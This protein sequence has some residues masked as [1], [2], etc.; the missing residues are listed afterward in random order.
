MVGEQATK[1]PWYRMRRYIHFDD[2]VSISAAEALVTNP[3]RVAKHAF[4]PL[5]GFRH[6]ERRWKRMDKKWKFKSRPIAYAS[7][8]DSHIF[9]YYSWVLGQLYEVALNTAGLSDV[10]LAYRKH[11]VNPTESDKGKTNYHFAAEAFEEIATRPSCEVVALDVERFFDTIPHKQM[12]AKWRWLLKGDD[13]PSDHYNIYKA[14]T[15][16]SVVTLTQIRKSL[17]IGRRKYSKLRSIGISSAEFDRL[18]R[19]RGLINVN[20][21]QY[22]IPQGLPISGLLANLVMFNVDVE[23]HN[24]AESAGASY[25]RY[26]DDILIIAPPGGAPG[27][28]AKLKLC[29][30]SLGL[31]VQDSKTARIQCE[32]DASGKL[33]ASKPISYLG[34]EFDG[35][36]VILRQQT[37]VR[38]QKRM[39]RSVRRARNAAKKSARPG[40]PIRIRRRDLYT[41][42]SHMLPHPETPAKK[43]PRGTFMKYASRAGSVVAEHGA[44]VDFINQIRR[45]LRKQFKQLQRLIDE[46]E[47]TL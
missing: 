47:R 4:W 25:R 9:A 44:R 1:P 42:F 11:V 28:E 38:F 12:K 23:M 30:G 14:V 13:L 40:Q 21:T 35:S 19:Q 20:R 46:A 6:R 37:L 2:P 31:S 33:V 18:I 29:L 5:I 26:S 22:G 3:E 32:R 16:F 41:R 39:A 8:A 36:R 17:D 7:H 34:L 43:R 15:N 10:V 24:A 45:Q 27:L